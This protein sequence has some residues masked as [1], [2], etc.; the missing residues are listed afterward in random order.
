MGCI[1]VIIPETSN[2]KAV[3]MKKKPNFEKI[4]AKVKKI[5]KNQRY[6]PKV[7]EADPYDGQ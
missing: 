4:S 5:I 2:P 1:N 7:I 6:K 3:K